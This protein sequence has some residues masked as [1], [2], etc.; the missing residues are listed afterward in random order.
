MTSSHGNVPSK[1]S[2][3]VDG[4]ASMATFF[5]TFRMK[6]KKTL[7]GSAGLT[8]I[9]KEA[10]KKKKKEKKEKNTSSRVC[11]GACVCERGW[12]DLGV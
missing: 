2:R 5:T 1:K 9:H 3:K 11:V 8:P 10:P 4:Y 12:L 6:P 7:P